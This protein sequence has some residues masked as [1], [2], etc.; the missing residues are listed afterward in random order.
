MNLYHLICGDHSQTGPIDSY[1]SP[2]T[3]SEDQTYDPLENIK[4][5]DNVG[6]DDGYH[7]W[8]E[9]SRKDFKTGKNI[10]YINSVNF[11]SFLDKSP[12]QYYGK[13][14][15]GGVEVNNYYSPF[16][17]WTDGDTNTGANPYCAP[18]SSSKEYNYWLYTHN[19]NEY[20]RYDQAAVNY[21]NVVARMHLLMPGV[22]SETQD[23]LLGIAWVNGVPSSKTFTAAPDAQAL[24]NW[25]D[26]V[27]WQVPRK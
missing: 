21:R 26:S 3:T 18:E 19:H 7:Y 9:P 23:Q 10:N 6:T 4:N 2:W 25:L 14:Q 1:D 24:A 12:S 5:V 15:L 8:N 11:F 17:K 13:T 20:A 22:V 16:Y 27:Y